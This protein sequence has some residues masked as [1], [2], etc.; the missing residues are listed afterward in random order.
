MSFAS[1]YS[2]SLII[3]CLPL[4][5]SNEIIFAEKWKHVWCH[6]RLKAQKILHCFCL[7]RYIM[8]P[9]SPSLHVSSVPRRKKSLF[10]FLQII[11]FPLMKASVILRDGPS[12]SPLTTVTIASR[13]LPC[14]P[15]QI[16]KFSHYVRIH[17]TNSSNHTVLHQNV[18]RE[19]LTHSLIH[20]TVSLFGYHPNTLKGLRFCVSWWCANTL[21]LFLPFPG[22]W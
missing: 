19:N 11:S 3:P 17:L 16:S 12:S 4:S 20:N 2:R 10:F 6:C 1:A 5:R 13:S 7:L 22:W 9:G 8:L 18:F 15:S 14:K 21:F